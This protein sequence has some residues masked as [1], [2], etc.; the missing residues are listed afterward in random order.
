M[1]WCQCPSV[2]LSVTEVNWRIIANLGFKFRSKFTAHCRCREG[3]FQQQHLTLCQPLLGLL[4]NYCINHSCTDLDVPVIQQLENWPQLRTEA[5][6]TAFQT[7]IHTLTS[8]LDL[9]F[10]ES[11]GHNPYTCK[12]S[13]S[14]VSWFIS[15]S[16]NRQTDRQ[17]ERIA[18]P[19]MLRRLVTNCESLVHQI[20]WHT[21]QQWKRWW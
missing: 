10:H 14:K 7:E 5:L 6:P 1:L 19:P 20:S 2:C 11:H 16:R 3:S 21:W 17:M 4:L 13:G 12:S 8:D 9:Q 15:Y 18:L